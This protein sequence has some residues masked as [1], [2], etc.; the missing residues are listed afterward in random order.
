MLYRKEKCCFL[1]ICMAILRKRRALFMDAM[2]LRRVELLNG[3]RPDFCQ[4]SWLDLQ[5]SS[6]SMIADSE[7]QKT[8]FQLLELW[9]TKNSTFRIVLH[10]RLVSL[11]MKIH[12]RIISQ[13]ILLKMISRA[14][15]S[16]LYFQF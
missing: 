12:K 13:F 3:Q 8:S 10:L 7:L 9:R 16:L 5:I 6:A 14:L 11:G 2:N 4:K 15:G 1:L